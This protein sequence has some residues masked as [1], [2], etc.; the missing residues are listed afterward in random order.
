VDES[1][2]TVKKMIDY[3]YRA[4]LD[5]SID[6]TASL[7]CL[8]LYAQIFSLA[9][10]YCVAG[11]ASVCCEKFELRLANE[12]TEFKGSIAS[13]Y[14]LTPATVRGLRDIGIRFAHVFF[15]PSFE[16]HPENKAT[17]ESV[18]KLF[19]DFSKDLLNLFI[20]KSS[21]PYLVSWDVPEPRIKIRCGICRKKMD[22]NRMIHGKDNSF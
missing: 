14:D 3:L 19:P 7:S 4:N 20:Q 22:Y 6:D 2:I 5:D 21:A 11:L 1:A 15:V 12:P 13:V 10:K 8:Q 18:E 17:Y 9:D 16:Q